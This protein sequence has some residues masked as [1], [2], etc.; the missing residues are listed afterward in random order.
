MRLQVAGLIVLTAFVARA[1]N[2]L[3]APT[4]SPSEGVP[5]GSYEYWV[6]IDPPEFA[7]ATVLWSMSA[8]YVRLPLTGSVRWKYSSVSSPVSMFAEGDPFCSSCTGF[9]SS[10]KNWVVLPF[11]VFA[12]RRPIASYVNAASNSTRYRG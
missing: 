8:R 11:T 12:T 6:M 7:N 2:V 1:A 9:E 4:D 5:N 10:Y 3:A